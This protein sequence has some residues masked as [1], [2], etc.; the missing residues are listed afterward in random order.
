MK[1]ILSFDL[2]SPKM[3]G[4]FWFSLNKLQNVFMQNRLCALN[5]CV[6][7]FMNKTNRLDS[8]DAPE[9][10]FTE[11]WCYKKQEMCLLAPQC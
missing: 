10:A 7:S 3:D 8:A 2:F 4:R 5:S 1:Y 11:P 6:M 9:L